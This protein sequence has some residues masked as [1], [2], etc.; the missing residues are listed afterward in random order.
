LRRLFS[1]LPH[2][3]AKNGLIVKSVDEKAVNCL[4]FIYLLHLKT[5]EQKNA[6]IVVHQPLLRMVI[7][8]KFRGIYANLA[9]RVSL[10]AKL[11]ILSHYGVIM[12]LA[13]KPFSN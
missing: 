5:Y 4:N 6:F 10:F 11:L 13:S 3:Y 7:K 2:Y 9:A 1:V 12:F 8:Y